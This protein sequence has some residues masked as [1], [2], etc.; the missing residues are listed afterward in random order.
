MKNKNH[1]NFIYYIFFTA[2]MTFLFMIIAYGVLESRC[3]KLNN[4]KSN[5][6]SYY[7]TEHIKQYYLY[8]HKADSILNVH[9]S[10]IK[11]YMLSDAWK[12][13]YLYKNID[14]PF[15]L[16]ISQ[17]QLESS[18]GKSRI[19]KKYNNPFNIMGKKDFI[20]Y[21]TLEEGIQAYYDL[22]ASKYLSCKS[23][24]ELTF[25]FVNCSNNRYAESQTYEQS[26][27]PLINKYAT[28]YY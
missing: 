27:K 12:N 19:A 24:K 28:L 14:V 2:C 4:N 3:N 6:I 16:A 25:N 8:K 5:K 11:G 26:L 1:Y 17:L 18:F 13:T 15:S 7:D 23:V 10:P 22:I 20:F 9:K 21:N